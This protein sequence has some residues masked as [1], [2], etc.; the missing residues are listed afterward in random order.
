MKY[1]LF[2]G[3]SYTY[4][5]E[6]PQKLFAEKSAAR[7]EDFHVTAVTRGGYKLSQFADPEN[8]EGKRLREVI[9]GKHFDWVV[10]Q[11][12]SCNPLADPE[13][14]L[15]GVAGLQEL[16]AEQTGNFVLY[17]TWGRK[18]GS[19]IPA[20]LTVDSVEMT[21]GLAAAYEVAGARFGMKV[22]HVGKAFAAHLQA[23]P[24]AELY[25]PD[26]SHPSLLGSELAA[27]T[28]LQTILASSVL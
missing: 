21:R 1:I 7:G 27:E 14:F 20:P 4:Y 17:A 10:L 6:M 15:R 24:E 12:Q 25:D 5:N 9:R 11:D 26:C 16:L 3:N 13:D 2:V 22:A 19:A 23:H 8:D 18:P 28:I